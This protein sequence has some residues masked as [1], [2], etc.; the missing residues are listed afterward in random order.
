MVRVFAN[1]PDSIPS[2]VIPKIQKILLDFS[3]LIL[4]IIKYGSRIIGAIQG[5][6]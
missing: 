2:R 4:S 1:G 3:C 5:K 6:E